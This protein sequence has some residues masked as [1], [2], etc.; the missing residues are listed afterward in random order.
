M[1]GMARTSVDHVVV[2]PLDEVI[3]S[4]VCF[5]RACGD[6]EHDGVAFLLAFAFPF[7]LLAPERRKRAEGERA[8]VNINRFPTIQQQSIC[9][10]RRYEEAPV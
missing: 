6:Q 1:G 9:C 2:V 8:H 3:P 5:M 7:P 4:R 10:C